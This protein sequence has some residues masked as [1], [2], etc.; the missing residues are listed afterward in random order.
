MMDK[1][2][3]GETAMD[4]AEL[5]AEVGLLGWIARGLMAVVRLALR[6]IG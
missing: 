6:A 4:A 2:D 3:K 1:A 5:A